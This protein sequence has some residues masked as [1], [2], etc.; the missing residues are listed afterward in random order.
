MAPIGLDF[1]EE[2]E[3][4]FCAEDGFE[5]FAGRGT[6]FFD[7]FP[8]LPYQNSLLTV[9]LDV[10][11]GADAQ[12]LGSFL[13]IINQDGYGVRNFVACGEDGFF[14]DDFGGEEAFRLVRELIGGKMWR[15][16][17][18]ARKPG[19]DQVE[20]AGA[21]E[22]A[23][24][25]NF[26]EFEFLAV[27]IDHR[28]E[29]LLGDAVHFIEQQVHRAVKA[30]EP[31][32]GEFIAAAEV[33]GS[34]GDEAED[35]NAFESVLEFVHHHAAED[36]F[37]FVDARSIYEDDLGVVA[38]EDALNAVA[39]GLGFGRDDGDFLAD[40]S[41]DEGGFA[42]VRAAN[43]RYETGLE[44]HGQVN[45]T[46]LGDGAREAERQEAGDFFFEIAVGTEWLRY[47][48]MRC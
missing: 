38:I 19:T 21:G 3:E 10:H 46:P 20:T 41:I 34:V 32:D 39:G 13:E 14:A 4:D 42:R 47:F 28:Q 33:D 22:S 9:A 25:K 24:G 26:G 6:D 23:D 5:F 45:C 16:F 1:D 29:Q 8:A 40:K 37:W 27:A 48:F 18:Q 35:V 43:D 2:L 31:F 15:S 11:R 44:G 7:G 17:G 30:L 12:E 36:V